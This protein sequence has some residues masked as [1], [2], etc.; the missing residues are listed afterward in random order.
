[1]KLNRL[2]TGFILGAL[3][4]AFTQASAEED[5]SEQGWKFTAKAY[6]WGQ[7]IGGETSSGEDVDISF[8]DIWENLNFA[9]MTWLVARNGNWLVFG[10]LQYADIEGDD[11]TAIDPGDGMT[12]RGELDLEFTQWVV[13]T[14]SLIHISEPTRPAPLSRMPSSA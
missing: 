9:M 11:N 8:S 4:A 3:M 14:L 2:I 1:M 13:Q 10:D 5:N 6:V 7:S 12:I